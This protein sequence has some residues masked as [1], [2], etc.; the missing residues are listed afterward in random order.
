MKVLKPN[1][2]QNIRCCDTK[3]KI[4]QASYLQS[5]ISKKTTGILQVF[6]VRYEEPVLPVQMDHALVHGAVLEVTHETARWVQ[7]HLFHLFVASRGI[8]LHAVRSG[9]VSQLVV[10]VL[11]YRGGGAHRKWRDASGSGGTTGLLR[12]G[13]HE[14]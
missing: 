14:M 4:C 12:G 1:N 3:E 11:F 6:A 9:F 5:N 8:R 13:S 2:K 7:V 10:S